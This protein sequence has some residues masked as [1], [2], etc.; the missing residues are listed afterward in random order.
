MGDQKTRA[1][2]VVLLGI[3]QGITTIAALID[4]KLL[5]TLICL[6][7]TISASKQI[8]AKNSEKDLTP[9]LAKTAQLQILLSLITACALFV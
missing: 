1:F 6:P 9:L 5:I 2:Y 7:L 3:S 4:I 8:Y